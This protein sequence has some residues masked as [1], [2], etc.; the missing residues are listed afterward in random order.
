MYHNTAIM[1]MNGINFSFM[2]Y[3]CTLLQEREFTVFQ[4]ALKRRVHITFDYEIIDVHTA[5]G[6][7][8]LRAVYS[9]FARR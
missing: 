6:V 7:R 1:Y 2:R 8:T 4:R 5:P 9:A 3:R